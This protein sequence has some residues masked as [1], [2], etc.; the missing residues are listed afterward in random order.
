MRQRSMTEADKSKTE[1]RRER[2]LTGEIPTPLRSY[3]QSHKEEGR[4]STSEKLST[5]NKQHKTFGKKKSS[6]STSTTRY[7]T[8]IYVSYNV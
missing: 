8:A 4:P 3:T 6:M 7:H 1:Q 5:N 2:T